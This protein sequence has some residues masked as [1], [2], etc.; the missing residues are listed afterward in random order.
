MDYK[1]RYL[2]KIV[3]DDLAD[4]MVFVGGPRQ[5]G[6]TTFAT[7][8]FPKNNYA[9]LNWDNQSHRNQ[10]I[11]SQFPEDKALIIFDELHK[12]RLWKSWL[13]GEYDVH[14]EQHQFLVTGS[15]R[16]DLYRKGGDALQG[17]YYHFRLHPFSLSEIDNK[18][19]ALSI[20]HALSFSE[21][22]AQETL[23]TLDRFG[24]FPEPF[25]GQSERTH[26]RWATLRIDRLFREDIRDTETIRDLSKM[27][28]LQQALPN[29]IGSLLSMNALREDLEV[30]HR[31][32]AHWMDVIES[33]Y[34][35][36]RIYPFC[37][38]NSLQALKK[39]PKLYLWDWSDVKD[40]GARFENMVG[41]HLLKTVHYLQDTDGYRT[42]LFFI[43]DAQKREVDFLVTVD[44]KPWFAVEVKLSDTHIARNLLY[45]KAQHSIPFAYQ[46]VKQS[47]IDYTKEGIRVISANKFLT[48]LV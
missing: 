23:E 19:P 6:K 38:K 37:N 36:Y 24:G 35:A 28:R 41:S 30:S 17:R 48:G 21:P 14:H 33:F 22:L 9:Y 7:H 11:K 8:L 3:K 46:V 27:Q 2:A 40:E 10:I 16:L 32:V 12:Y 43:R 42:E 1:Q 13:K 20:M 47:G 31:T 5:V 29:K 34:Y 18:H 39:E 15:A 44:Q 4:K 45:F 25:L 26:R